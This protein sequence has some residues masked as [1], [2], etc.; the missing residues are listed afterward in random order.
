MQMK[1]RRM[2]LCV[3]LK[4]EWAATRPSSV[5]KCLWLE[6]CTCGPTNTARA[7]PASSTAFTPA[8]SGTNTTRRIT[9]STTRHPRSSRAT[10]STSSTPISSTN[11]QLHSTSSSP[12][13]T[14]KTLEFCASTPDRRTR[15]SPSRSWTVN[16]SIP[17]G[18]ASA[19][20]SPMGSFSCG[21]TLSGTATDGEEEDLLAFDLYKPSVDYREHWTFIFK[22]CKIGVNLKIQVQT[23]FIDATH[24][25]R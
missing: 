21:S 14:T 13:A 5:W 15:T 9:T 12:Q 6:K 17:I 8:S 3:A 10:S 18:M 25:P 7:S 4:R 20:S 22:C 11:A 19:A 23:L 1:V 2:H 16:G 24:I